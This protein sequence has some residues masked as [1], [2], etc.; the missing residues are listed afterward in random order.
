VIDQNQVIK[1][2]TID[3]VIVFTDLSLFFWTDS[4][5][6]VVTVRIQVRVFVCAE[7]PSLEHLV[8]GSIAGHERGLV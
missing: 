7:V 3:L 4:A 6:Q 8:L 1:T 5:C 2:R